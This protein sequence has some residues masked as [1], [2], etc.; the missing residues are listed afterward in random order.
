MTLLTILQSAGGGGGTDVSVTPAQQDLVLTGF[1]PTVTA[2][3]NVTVSPAQQALV[4][5]GQAPTVSATSNATVTPDPAALTITGYAPSVTVP[6]DATVE[7][8]IGELVITGYEPSVVAGPDL[9]LMDMHDGYPREDTAAQGQ[10]DREKR[11]KETLRAAIEDAMA[12]TLGLPKPTELPV[13]AVKPVPA[14]PI[15]R[16][17]RRQIAELLARSG[18]APRED[19]SVKEI[20]A[21]IRSV[22]R[23]LRETEARRIAL[24]REI[25]EE[26]ELILLWSA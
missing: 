24:E 20:E 6:N 3:Q 13:D 10:R 23:G 7:P 26:D 21:E 19:Y 17:H 18:I 8:G 2:E 9:S 16:E 15:N 4:L 5:T 12:E 22:E 11:N 14:R 1:A 25:E